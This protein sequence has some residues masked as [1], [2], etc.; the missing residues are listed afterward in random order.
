MAI[1]KAMIKVIAASFIKNQILVNELQSL[2]PNC[3]LY[4][5]LENSNTQLL[6]FCK[7]AEVLLVGR[8]KIDA[9]F[10]NHCPNLK[11]IA[12]YG[13]GIDNIDQDAL[14]ARNIILGWTGGV[15]KRSVAELTIGF[16]LSAAHNTFL[17]GNRL[18]KGIWY[19]NGGVCIENK[20]LGIIGFGHIGTEV[21]NLLQPFGMRILVHDIIHKQ[22]EA[23]ALN[24]VECDLK[25]LQSESD[26]ITLHVPYTKDTEAFINAEFLSFCKKEMI[27]INCARG[28][29]IHTE[30]IIEA[31]E[32]G[33][34]AGYYT[35]AYEPEPYLDQRLIS[36]ETF[37]GSTHIGGNSIEAT[38]NMGR[39]AIEH[40]KNYY[41]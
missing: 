24:A 31:L 1:N 10:L 18:K 22:K 39:S 12:K 40:I 21:A 27:L 16:L 26:F 9:A 25:T 6:D 8:E 32:N 37:F 4:S 41:Q 23:T 3:V 38:L 33:N 5:G 35:D 17:T 11:L 30:Q 2:F 7:D 20:T 19:K 34:L 36:Q 13:V 14:R 29:I 28:E 15:N